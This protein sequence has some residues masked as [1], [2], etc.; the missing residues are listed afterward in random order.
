MM[1]MRTAVLVGIDLARLSGE[2]LADGAV[3]AATSAAE[4]AR[5]RGWFTDWLG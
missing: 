2:Y 4:L 1:P 3:W 5:K